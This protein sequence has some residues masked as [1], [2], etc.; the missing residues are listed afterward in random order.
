MNPAAPAHTPQLLT[1]GERP[2][3]LVGCRLDHPVE[4]VWEAITV[5]GLLARW[6]PSEVEFELRPGGTVTFD[7][8]GESYAGQV[9]TAEPPHR[10]GFTWEEDRLEFTLSGTGDGQAT[11]LTLVHAFDDLAGAAS[12]ATGWEGCFASLAD[13]LAGR[14]P[15]DPGRRVARHEELV[16]LFG[17]DR[18]E[19]TRGED[20]GW[21]AAWE[22]QLTCPAQAAW[23]LWFGTD[24]DTGRQR[25]TPDIGAPFQ[26][27]GAPDTVLGT[28][29]VVDEPREFVLDIAEDV[30]GNTLG[31][32]LGDGTGHGARLYLEV[33][34]R[35]EDLDAA[36]EL[37][38]EGA[39]G[40]LA[41][42][43]AEQD[44]AGR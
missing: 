37:W 16:A 19:V 13:V 5:P 28:A 34:G 36:L 21:R 27:S 9:L 6:F 3:V 12:F 40:G 39:L 18:P 30:A 2:A 22:R 24:R 43:A 20:G 17:L 32:R 15:V 14:E 1:D 7:P 38:G 8:D 33:T 44:A 42:A 35:E 31:L 25:R 29:R 11:D 26:H 41:R 10:L 4:R 23:D